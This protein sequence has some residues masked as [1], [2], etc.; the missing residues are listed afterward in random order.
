MP[1]KRLS[2]I[3]ILLVTAAGILIVSTIR[4]ADSASFESQSAALGI[5][6]GLES[7]LRRSCYE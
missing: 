6:A 1:A 2:G 7:G 5:S 3:I 4:A